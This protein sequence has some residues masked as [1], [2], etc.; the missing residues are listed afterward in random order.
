[1][2]QILFIIL[3]AICSVN[4]QIDDKTT[5]TQLNQ[6]VVSLYKSGNL[7]E[8]LKVAQNSLDLTLKTYG[9]ESQET[10]LA[11]TNLGNLQREKG[12][13]N[14]ALKNLK[15]ALEIYRKLPDF[16]N[17]KLIEIY[18]KIGFTEFLAGKRT[19][20]ETSYLMA[21][22]IAETIYGS[23]SKETFLPN[24]NLASVYARN[25]SFVKAD[26]F[27]LKSYTIARK[28]FGNESKEVEQIA[29]SRICSSEDIDMKRDELFND[30]FNKIFGVKQNNFTSKIINGKARQLI[31]PPYPKEA[32]EKRLTGT[33]KIRVTI[34]E[35]GNVIEAKSICGNGVL[36]K[37]SEEAA[38]IS[39]FS[40][41]FLDDKAVKVT[42]LIVYRF[43]TQ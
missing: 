7:D 29:N 16:S 3:F 8:S 37:V 27:Y 36:E 1:M 41:T 15:T 42:G 32:K 13:Y 18:Q 10:Y 38:F 17:T 4:A 23:E 9:A 2:K 43:A 28:N 30:E 40:P 35:Q 12:K 25:N 11:Y 22:N 26:E 19:E 6:Q 33:I 20:A 34:N 24:L 5:I 31:K 21:I 39:K 14:D